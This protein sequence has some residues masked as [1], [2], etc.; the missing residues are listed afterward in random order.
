[1]PKPKTKEELEE[2]LLANLPQ[3]SMVVILVE[4]KE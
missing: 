1:M 4:P 2:A 3:V